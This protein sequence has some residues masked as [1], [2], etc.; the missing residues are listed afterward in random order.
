MKSCTSQLSLNVVG[1]L[2]KLQIPASY[3]LSSGSEEM[4]SGVATYILTITLKY[5]FASKVS[6]PAFRNKQYSKMCL[7]QIA[8]A[9][10]L[11]VASDLEGVKGKCI[12][13]SKQMKY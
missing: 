7:G 11:E 4:G 6:K 3:L 2:T 13:Y 12:C 10:L 5:C 8:D 1:E 9:V